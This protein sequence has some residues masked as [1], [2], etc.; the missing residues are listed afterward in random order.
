MAQVLAGYELS[1]DRFFACDQLRRLAVMCLEE[2]ALSLVLH[3]FH[4]RN[5]IQE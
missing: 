3:A 2:A 5:S 1:G 4:V